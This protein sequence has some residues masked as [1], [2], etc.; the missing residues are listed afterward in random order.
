MEKKE[1]GGG[2]WEEGE[3][4]IEELE[5]ASLCHGTIVFWRAKALLQNELLMACR[6]HLSIML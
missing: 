6:N 1:H 5:L 2:G 4:V 3:S